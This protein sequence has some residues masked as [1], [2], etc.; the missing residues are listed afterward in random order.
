MTG[1]SVDAESFNAFEAAGWEITAAAYG[2]FFGRVT[3]RVLET[4]LEAPDIGPGVCVRGVAAGPGDEAADSWR[5]RP[6]HGAAQARHSPRV[7]VFV[8]LSSAPRA[9]TSPEHRRWE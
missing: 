6:P 9:T 5:L 4:L 7:P 8:R 3:P 1:S 2:D